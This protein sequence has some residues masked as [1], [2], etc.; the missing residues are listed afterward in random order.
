MRIRAQ[1][2][3]Q[4]MRAARR[5]RAQIERN[6][7]DIDVSLPQYKSDG[8]NGKVLQGYKNHCIKGILVNASEATAQTNMNMS[9]SGRKDPASH[10]LIV[11]YNKHVDLKYMSEFKVKDNRAYRVTLIENVDNLDLYYRI[12]CKPTRQVMEG[13]DNGRRN[14]S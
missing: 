10:T 12:T 1:R 7:I 8:A 4:V 13:Y 6:G 14:H 2:E 9:D 5:L 3:H 11:L